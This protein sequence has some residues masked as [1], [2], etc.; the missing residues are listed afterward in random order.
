MESN[1]ALRKLNSKSGASISFALV[2][3]IV[4]TMVSL[5]IVAAALTNA[6]K[7]RNEL[8]N[9][10]AYLVAESVAHILSDQIVSNVYK[11]E[12]VN[13][14]TN[15]YVEITE[16][17][18]GINLPELVAKAPEAGPTETEPDK[19]LSGPIKGML[20]KLCLAR[21]N[22]VYGKPANTVIGQTGNESVQVFLSN[23]TD[24]S[25]GKLSD[26]VL[27]L[28]NDNTSV[29]CYMPKIK[30]ENFHGD[31][32]SDNYDLDFLITVPAGSRN[33]TC[34]LHFD[35]E[36]RGDADDVYVYWPSSKLVKGDGSVEE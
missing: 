22:A 27:S 30:S 6:V 28:I 26:D 17:N 32:Y 11:T 15:R 19:F 18:D 33:Y 16:E 4:A 5:V 20:E 1:N 2:A 3:F 31:F 21:Y 14:L 9:E 34:I 35:A 24:G 7:I 10:Q 25:S 12:G 8:E 13:K 29:V 23:V 36:I